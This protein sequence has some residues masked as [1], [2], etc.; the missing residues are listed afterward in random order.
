MTW[1]FHFLYALQNIHTTI[2]DKIM[3]LLSTLGN[4]G[5]MWIGMAIALS[6]NRKTRKLGFQMFIAMLVAFILGN[7][8]L[9]NFIQRQRPCW[10][11]DSI[12][13]LIRNPKDFSFPSGHS[14]NGFVAATTIFLND[15]KAGIIAIIA[16]GLIAFSR[17]YLFVHFPTDVLC[18]IVLGIG[19]AIFVNE[20][21][22]RWKN[23]PLK[24]FY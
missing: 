12:K 4:S 2:L 3:V 21:F 24:K 8:I 1:E 16:A 5:A 14:L 7:G 18:G 13:L 6:I 17:L 22:K 9:K 23:N 19:I 20:V 11:D 10:I 15:R